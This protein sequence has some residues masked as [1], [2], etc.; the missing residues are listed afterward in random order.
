M[1]TFYVY[2][3]WDPIKEEPFYV[4]K[5]KDRPGCIRY[6]DHF[7]KALGIKNFSDKN[8]HK[9]NRIRKIIR[10]GSQPEVKI[11]METEDELVAFEKEIELIKFYGRRD[12][13]TGSLTNMTDG[14]EGQ[15]GYVYSEERKRKI[16][17]RVKG[18]GNPMYGRTHTLEARKAISEARKKYPTYYHTEEW[19][20]HLRENNA[21]GKATAIPV[22]QIGLEGNIIAKWPSAKKA[23]EELDYSTRTNMCSC[24]KY[25][26]R[27]YKG[28]YW[29]YEKDVEIKN[30][31]LV[32][33]DELNRQRLKPRAAKGIN[34]YDLSGVFIKTWESQLQIKRELNLSNSTISDIIRGKR[35]SEYGGFKWA[36]EQ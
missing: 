12:K 2:E 35:N 5:G 10:T 15:S 32:N 27:T 23:A 7:K 3:L 36:L 18:K 25:K 14:G 19:K 20:Q 24:A 22:Y 34:Q 1:Q 13:K 17:F 26:Y 29:L 9:L 4:G 33:I 21:G 8:Y 6:E 16:G 31:K 30:N 28:Y 11:I